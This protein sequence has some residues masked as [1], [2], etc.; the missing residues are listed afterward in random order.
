MNIVLFGAPLSGK[1]TQADLIK[2]KYGLVHIS[3]GD[4]LR[5]IA[6]QNTELGFQVNKLLEEGKLIPDEIIIKV[7]K[8][9]LISI[10]SGNG[11]ILDGFPRT[12]YQAEILEKVLKIDYVIYLNTAKDSIISR[13]AGRY[14]CQDCKRTFAVKED[15]DDYICPDCGGKLVKRDDDNEATVIKRYDAFIEF[16]TPVIDFYRKNGKLIEFDGNSSIQEIFNQ[17]QSRLK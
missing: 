17:I 11:I 7:L 14:N 3:T 15:S 13:I 16:S 12:L 6:K 1:G 2:K 10:N 9:K 5:E 8:E 4:M